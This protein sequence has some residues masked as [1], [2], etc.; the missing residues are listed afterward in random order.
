MD[1]QNIT[2]AIPKELLHDAK[3]LAATRR[4]SMSSLIRSLLAE[5]VN[6]E[7][8]NSEKVNGGIQK[9]LLTLMEE[10]IDYGTPVRDW[11]REELYEERLSRFRPD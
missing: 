3:A 5:A 1:T 6:I 8:A 7:K 11:T 2:L 9:S 10:G 4:V